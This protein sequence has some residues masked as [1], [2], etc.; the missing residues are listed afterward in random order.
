MRKSMTIL[1]IFFVVFTGHLTWAE[2][3]GEFTELKKELKAE[4][5]TEE[6]R[7]RSA[8][9]FLDLYKREPTEE[10]RKAMAEMK[11]LL[12]KGVEE[13]AGFLTSQ[14]KKQLK[15]AIAILDKAVK[16]NVG[17]T[18][19]QVAKIDQAG[20]TMD[21]AL[22][23]FRE[24]K[25]LEFRKTLSQGMA[26]RFQAVSVARFPYI[27][28]LDTKEGHVW[29][30]DGLNYQEQYPSLKYQGQIYPVKN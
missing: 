18:S 10:K 27:L 28:V 13:Y 30:W 17:I 15:E 23:A 24:A 2:E 6:K 5:A 1:I 26:G 29:V 25:K 4:A 12:E 14:Q 19:Q 7:K 8:E 3:K 20:K 21:Q 11:T 9:E 22:A 16:E